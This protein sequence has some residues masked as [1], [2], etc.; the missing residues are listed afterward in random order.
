MEA[1]EVLV[2]DC[3]P[4][5]FGL[6]AWGAWLLA[7]VCKQ[8]CCLNSTLRMCIMVIKRILHTNVM[9]SLQAVASFIDGMTLLGHLVVCTLQCGDDF[10]ADC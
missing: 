6:V 2:N 1:G 10:N 8:Q 7:I 5:S 4:S 9:Q 3:L